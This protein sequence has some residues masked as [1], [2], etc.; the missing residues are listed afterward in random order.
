MAPTGWYL[1]RRRCAARSHELHSQDRRIW[2]TR[3]IAVRH[4][5]HVEE[6]NASL[7]A[8][9][10]LRPVRFSTDNQPVTA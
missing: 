1:P 2:K 9:R 8:S 3:T 6:L 4:R 10:S 5:T 7:L